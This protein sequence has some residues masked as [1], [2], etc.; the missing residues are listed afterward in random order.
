MFPLEHWLENSVF[1]CDN[2]ASF[3][4]LNSGSTRDAL[5]QILREICLYAANLQ[6]EVKAKHISGQNNRLP[7][8]L[9]RWEID[10]KYRT[11]FKNSMATIKDIC[12]TSI[13][14]R[15]KSKFEDSMGDLFYIL[16]L[17]WI[18]VSSIF[19]KGFNIICTISE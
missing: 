7:G 3:E 14:R 1:F 18:S 5:M 16:F 15:H 10:I 2:D 4:V 9:S 11:L 12:K 6:F 8:Y 13:C 17:F 19:R